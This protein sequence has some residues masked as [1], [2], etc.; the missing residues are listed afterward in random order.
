M[1]KMKRRRG[2]GLALAL[3]VML[4][5]A[6][7][8]QAQ[9]TEAASVPNPPEEAA[10]ALP[11]ERRIALRHHWTREQI[12]VVYRIGDAYQPEAMAAINK[13]M[14]DYRCQKETQ[15]DPGLIDLLYELQQ[16]L[17][18]T[19]P[20]RIV[21]AY[22]SE[23]YNASL[24]RA[25]RSVDPDSQHT[26]GHAAD[27]IFPGVKPDALRA[28]AEA[29]GLGGVGYYPFS[30]PVFVHVDTGPVRHW[31]ERDPRERRVIATPKR[32]GRMVLD[33]SLTTEQ[34]LAEVSAAQ[35]YAAL[36]P[37][38]STK[39]H[40]I[41]DLQQTS[42]TGLPTFI[43]LQPGADGD[44]EEES[45]G[46]TC[47]GNDPLAPLSLMTASIRPVQMNVRMRTRKLQKDKV[48]A[49]V[50]SARRVAQK[51]RRMTPRKLIQTRAQKRKK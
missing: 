43:P 9:T 40:P 46:P 24:L 30:G 4:I 38:A 10:A 5:G 15:M 2:L 14:R 3:T 34:A 47:Q 37:G 51:S 12:D 8:G 44:D 31:T 26:R 32:R 28:A 41:G 42:V 1:G 6:G 22:R 11:Q 29:R 7:K 16:Q 27:V 18:P 23:G 33:C 17:K 36:P 25:G 50:K 48:K 45:E 13:L 49:Q 20:I 39:P 19:G 35:V 21:S